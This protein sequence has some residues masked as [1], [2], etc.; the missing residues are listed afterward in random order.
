VRD[1]AEELAIG[2]QSIR[3]MWMDVSDVDRSIIARIL[4][5]RPNLE[6][7]MQQ[8]CGLALPKEFR[9]DDHLLIGCMG[10]GFDKR[11]FL[12]NLKTKG[13][14]RHFILKTPIPGH[15]AV[16]GRTAFAYH[17][18]KKEKADDLVVRLGSVGEHW[19]IEEYFQ[20]ERITGWQEQIDDPQAS[21]QFKSSFREAVIAVVSEHMALVDRGATLTNPTFRNIL[22]RKTGRIG[23]KRWRARIVDYSSLSSE[24]LPPERHLFKLYD[25]LGRG[26]STIRERIPYEF[27]FDGVLKAYGEQRGVRF[28]QAAIDRLMQQADAQRLPNPD[29]IRHQAL[30]CY[31]ASYAD[32]GHRASRNI[33][34]TG[35]DTCAPERSE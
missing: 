29:S 22:V 3:V 5:E 20:G 11:V 15:E 32:I 35:R 33:T 1:L 8:I 18:L 14:Y 16:I 27:I 24:S 4:G 12:L 9:P 17:K 10:H 30:E 25:S 26:F 7:A 21:E 28:L 13:G 2:E 34:A 6:N 19:M 23:V 31:L